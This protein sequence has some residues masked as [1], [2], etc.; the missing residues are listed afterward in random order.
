MPTDITTVLQYA[1]KR[2][3]LSPFSVILNTMDILG[4]PPLQQPV[5]PP[6]PTPNTSPSQVLMKHGRGLVYVYI[7]AL[8]VILLVIIGLV[9]YMYGHHAKVQKSPAAKKSSSVTANIYAGWNTYSNDAAGIMFRYPTNWTGQTAESPLQANGSFGGVSGT[10]VSR[11]GN[12]LNWVY[13]EGGSKSLPACTPSPKDVPFAQTNKCATKQ[14]LYVEQLPTITPKP[15]RLPQSLFGTALYLTETKYQ[16]GTSDG[17][18]SNAP[19]YQICLDPYTGGGS[20]SPPVPGTVM[21]AE[22]PCEYN[23]GGFNVE[24]TVQANGFASADALT[25][26]KIMKSFNSYS[27][28]TGA[29]AV[30][31]VQSAYTTALNYV[32]STSF[33][34][35]AEINA[36]KGYLDPVFYAQLLNNSAN[37]SVD[38][39]LCNQPTPTSFTTGLYNTIGNVAYVSVNEVL[40][41]TQSSLKPTTSEVTVAVNLNSMAISNISCPTASP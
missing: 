20:D 8:A 17:Q 38:Q 21:G 11:S 41:P 9:F 1:W 36:I 23:G 7:G 15:D 27:A 19:T 34:G 16:A 35:E 33:N 6:E 37:I 32:N 13:Q 40:P 14:T 10:L 29:D 12:K 26:I 5:P 4:Q 18:A 31:T 28:R 39:V 2:L 30:N 24:F 22:M 3:W 25:A